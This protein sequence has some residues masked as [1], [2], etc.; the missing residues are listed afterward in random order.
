MRGDGRRRAAAGARLHLPGQPVVRR[1]RPE[2]RE[3]RIEQRQVDHLA[4]RRRSPRP[5]AARS[6]PPS[7]RRARRRCRRGTSAAAPARGRRSRSSRRSPTC[8]RPACRSRDAA[9]RARPGP[10]RRRA[11]RPASGLRREQHLRAE[12]H[13]LQRAGPEAL[14][15]HCAAG[16]QLQQQLARLGLAQV[17]AQ[18]LLVARVDLP[19]VATPSVCQARSVSPAGGSTF[20][21]SAPKSASAG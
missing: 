6:A 9:G 11:R 13:R 5:R 17:E 18:A 20:T 3:Q 2:Q 1:L 14:D 7:R 4:A 16:D 10:S 8:P 12:P 15:E 19:V 21:T